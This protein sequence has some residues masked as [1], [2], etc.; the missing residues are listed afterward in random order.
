MISDG[1]E[2]RNIED[3][4]EYSTPYPMIFGEDK[5]L[6]RTK[7]LKILNIGRIRKY[8][9]FKRKDWMYLKLGNTVRRHIVA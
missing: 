1:F 4:R 9:V 8:N 2:D 7:M 3:I 6:T 5:L